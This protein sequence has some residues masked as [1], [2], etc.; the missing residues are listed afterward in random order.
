MN[1][2]QKFISAEANSFAENKPLA[3]RNRRL[4]SKIENILTNFRISKLIAENIASCIQH[5][6]NIMTVKF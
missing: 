6:D 3:L 4:E 2:N 5:T 1:R